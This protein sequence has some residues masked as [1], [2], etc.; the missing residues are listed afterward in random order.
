MAFEFMRAE[1]N[2]A[3]IEKEFLATKNEA[4][5]HGETVKFSSG[6]LTKASGTDKPEF[7]YIGKDFTPATSGVAIAV[8]P[9]LPEYEFETTFSANA[10][11]VKAGAK[12]TVS[13]DG[14][15]AT[16]T[17]TSGVFQLLEDGQAANGRAVGRFA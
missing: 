5:K 17:T 15:Q 13:S 4:Y 12:V 2:A 11:A 8:V 14:T 3:P 10:A 1:N 9:V 6:K 7:V 16:A